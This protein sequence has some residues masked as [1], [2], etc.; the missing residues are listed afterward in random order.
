M[1][2]GTGRNVCKKRKKKKFI[3]A[4]TC[5]SIV[6]DCKKINARRKEKYVAGNERCIVCGREKGKKERDKEK[7]R[8]ETEWS[9]WIRTL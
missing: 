1:P 4:T 5:Q 6:L 8:I 3:V 2:R 9:E 7:G